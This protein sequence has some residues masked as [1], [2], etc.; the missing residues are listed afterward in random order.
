MV[1]PERSR[2]IDAVADLVCGHPGPRTAVGIDGRSGSG[3]STFAD[4]LAAQLRRRGRR[5]VRSTTDSFHRPRAERM[6]RGP[7][8]AEGYHLDSHQ[9]DVI[10]DELLT[11]FAA[12]APQVR[13]SAFDEPSD[14]PIDHTTEVEPEAVLIFDGLF[15]HRP[16]L[17]S[18]WDLSVLL[19]A[20]ARLDSEWLAFLLHD[21]PDDD[22]ARADAID[23]RLSRAR[24]PRYRD[25]WRRYVD[26]ADPS[27]AATIVI[28]N[29]D[30]AHPVLVPT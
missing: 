12:G 18:H 5:I 30:V 26:G 21:L 4:E 19:V 24:W 7:T 15:V 17:V 14:T 3:K 27:S 25:G 9:V 1:T 11:P 16:E 13:T 29:D 28:D 23:D 2:V 22:T 6:R 20:D 10:V 8:S